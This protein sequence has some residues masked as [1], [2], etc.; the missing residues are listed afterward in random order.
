MMTPPLSISA[1]PLL[2]RKV[3]S[4]RI[5]VSLTAGAWAPSGRGAICVSEPSELPSFAYKQMTVL[6]QLERANALLVRVLV[7]RVD[8]VRE[9][10]DQRQE[11]R[12]RARVRRAVR[13]VVDA[14]VRELGELGQARVGDSDRLALPLSRQLE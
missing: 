9:R 6:L 7:A 5:E 12:V 1:R 14:A 8:P 3:A 13:G 4:S 10:L 2:T 11:R